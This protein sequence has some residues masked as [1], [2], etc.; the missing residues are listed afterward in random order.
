MNTPGPDIIHL[1]G[2]EDTPETVLFGTLRVRLAV[3][4]ALFDG[5]MADPQMRSILGAMALYFTCPAPDG[6]RLLLEGVHT[7]EGGANVVHYYRSIS[8]QERAEAY[9]S[10]SLFAMFEIFNMHQLELCNWLILNTTREPTI[11]WFKQAPGVQAVFNYV[12]NRRMVINNR[13][14]SDA[15]SIELTDEEMTALENV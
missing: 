14:D 5:C 9:E 3:M 11:D 4:R 8:E 13:D 12:R 7:G 6:L 1:T 10:L 2:P 15:E